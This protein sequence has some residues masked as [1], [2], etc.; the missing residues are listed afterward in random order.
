MKNPGLRIPP[1]PDKPGLGAWIALF[2]VC[3]VY[4][5]E[6]VAMGIIAD[7]LWPGVPIGLA[8]LPFIFLV[9][10]RWAIRHWPWLGPRG[11]KP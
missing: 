4:V 8:V 11:A 3:T 9:R 7:D 5:V 10:S 2:V 1:L 6:I